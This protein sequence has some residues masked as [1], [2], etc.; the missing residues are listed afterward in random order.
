MSYYL[1]PD[2]FS[3][4][5]VKVILDLPDYATWKELDHATSVATT[6][7]AVKKYFIAFKTKIDKLGIYKFEN[8]PTSLNDLKTKVSDLDVA[9]LRT[10]PVYLKKVSDL[11][12]SVVA[13]NTKF[14]KL[15]TKAD[16]Y[17]KNSW[18]NYFNSHKTIQRR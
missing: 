4:Y 8:V 16:S 14:D 1:K 7:S 13:K 18:C 9:K 10:V 3:I 17:K 6:D 11:V 2:N 15:K 5:K 12:D